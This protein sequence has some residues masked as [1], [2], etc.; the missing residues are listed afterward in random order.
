MLEGLG[1]ELGRDLGRY[2]FSVM[3][4]LVAIFLFTFIVFTELRCS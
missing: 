3:G 1:E 4:S 2:F